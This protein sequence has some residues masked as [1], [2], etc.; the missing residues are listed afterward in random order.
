MGESE[1]FT[2][3]VKDS[4]DPPATEEQTFTIYVIEPVQIITEVIPDALQYRR[5]VTDLDVSRGIQPY[6]FEISSGVLPKGIVL[7]AL[8]GIISGFPSESS[9]FPFTVRLIDSG[10]PPVIRSKFF[11]IQVFPGQP[12][13]VIGGDLDANE[14]VGLSDLVVA[15]QALTNFRGVPVFMEADFNNNRRVDLIDALMIMD[16]CAHSR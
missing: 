7:D 8:W 9:T 15:L 10:T 2:I 16:A 14:Q 12:P 11:E 4:A 6:T 5:Y 13:V 3:Q 1:E